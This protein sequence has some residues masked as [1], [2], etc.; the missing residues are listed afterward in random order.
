MRYKMLRSIYGNDG[1]HVEYLEANIM[2]VWREY[3]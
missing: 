3:E 2:S 1:N